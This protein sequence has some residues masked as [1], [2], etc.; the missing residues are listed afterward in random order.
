M[1]GGPGVFLQKIEKYTLNFE[2]KAWWTLDRHRLCPTTGDNVLNP[3][4][5]A[6]IS[7]LMAVYEFGVGEFLA[8]DI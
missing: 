1:V 4:Y 5:V 8:R 3:V 7:G 6:L 2:A